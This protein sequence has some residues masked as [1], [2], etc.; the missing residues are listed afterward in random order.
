MMRK[1]FGCFSVLIIIAAI[2]IGALLVLD[3]DLPF[4]LPF[5]IGEESPVVDLPTQPPPPTQVDVVVGVEPTPEPP[6]ITESDNCETLVQAA[7]IIEAVEGRATAINRQPPA[8]NTRNAPTQPDF[9]RRQQQQRSEVLI[10]FTADSSQSERTEYIRS[11]GGTNKNSI[12][13]LNIV[14]TRLR[15]NV[16]IDSLPDSPIVEYAELNYTAGAAQTVSEPN[17]Q[18]YFEQWAFPAIGLPQA[19]QGLEGN[20]DEVIVAVVDSGICA[21]HPDLQGRLLPGVSF[22]D[23]DSSVNDTYNHGCGVAGVIAANANNSIGIA[24][25]APNAKILPI[26]VLD[27]NGLGGYAEI[28]AGIIYAVDNGADVI[29][30]SLAGPSSS[31]ALADAV[32]YAINRDVIV[33]AASGNSGLNTVWYPAA[34]PGVIAVGSID[35]NMQRSSFSNHSARINMLA[36]GR[37]IITTS[38]NGDYNLMTGT[39]FAAPQVSGLAALSKAL[40]IPLNVENDIVY[41]YPPEAVNDCTPN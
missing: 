13:K 34:L 33:V 4:S 11:I 3:V 31:Q 7:G 17:D 28:I 32:A 37:D 30:L 26:R 8:N 9:S 18:R 24:G 12:D 23:G 15:P 25:V 1:L 35:P 36:P 40:G 27:A 2:G 22:V 39:S 19:W 21:S 6:P 14:I 38:S 5:G 10:R 41:L 29:N 16:T 20:T